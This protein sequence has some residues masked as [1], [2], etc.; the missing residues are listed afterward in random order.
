MM[1]SVVVPAYNEEKYLP[2]TLKRIAQGLSVAGCP[3]E[4]V[5][6]DN[7]SQD[8]TKEI[9]KGFGAGVF[10]ETDHNIAR[11]RNTGAENS[12]GDLLIFV[13]AD[14]LVPDS[15]FLK[16]AEVMRDENC[17][18]GAVSV[19]YEEFQRRWVRFYILGW[20]FW[21]TVFNTKQGATQFCRRTVFSELGGYDV[22]VYVGED[23]EFYWR[24]SKLAKQK[25][26]F[27]SFIEN[28]KVK[29]SAR[30]FDKMSW[31]KTLLL[32]NP[33]F[34]ALAWKRKR[35]WQDWYEKAVR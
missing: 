15:L 4:I 19:E 33:F 28:P 22:G 35:F 5:V 32:T 29:T 23:V 14:T 12:K 31:W 2:E 1:I 17:L 18:G 34:I 10:T 25:A 26:A 9:A 8:R 13:D 20:K 3:S 30:R 21:E 16:I 24:L 27:V 6:V 7:D 11:V